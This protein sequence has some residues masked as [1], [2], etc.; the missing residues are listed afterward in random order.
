MIIVVAI[1][2][3]CLVAGAVSIVLDVRQDMNVLRYH[4]ERF[5]QRINWL[6]QYRDL[7]TLER[8]QL[9]MMPKLH[10]RVE[11][12]S[13]DWITAGV[14]AKRIPRFGGETLLDAHHRRELTAL[15]RQI[16]ADYRGGLFERLNGRPSI[17]STTSLT[18]H[19]R[20]N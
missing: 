20:W 10:L 13:I 8:I 1:L 9:V 2:G 16:M 5:H 19:K 15:V 3:I 7:T 6:P 12:A 11:Q 4:D 14:A 17:R 18:D